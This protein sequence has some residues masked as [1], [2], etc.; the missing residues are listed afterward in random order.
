MPV[1]WHNRRNLPP[2]A[3]AA[4]PLYVADSLRPLLDLI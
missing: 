3:G 4:Q 2:V 1:F